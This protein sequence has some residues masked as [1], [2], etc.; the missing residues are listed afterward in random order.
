MR[1]RG[2]TASV[3]RRRSREM[4]TRLSGSETLTS[5]DTTIQSA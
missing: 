3:E 2:P 1:A 4:L 5:F